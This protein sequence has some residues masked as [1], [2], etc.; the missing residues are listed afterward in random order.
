MA[1]K[2]EGQLAQLQGSS[3]LKIKVCNG[4]KSGFKKIED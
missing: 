2:K 3:A 4:A 1:F